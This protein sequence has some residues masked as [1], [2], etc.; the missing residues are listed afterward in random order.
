MSKDGAIKVKV[1]M[2]DVNIDDIRQACRRHGK[3]ERQMMRWMGWSRGFWW[4]VRRQRSVCMSISDCQ[5]L[6][7]FLNQ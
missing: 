5:R 6:L 1:S 4:R 3:S 2:V 7:M